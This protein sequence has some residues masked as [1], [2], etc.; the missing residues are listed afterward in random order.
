MSATVNAK[1]FINYFPIP[2]FKFA[3]IDAGEIPFYPIQEYFLE[4][5]GITIFSHFQK[6]VCLPKAKVKN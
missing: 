6:M 3:M 2:E 4:K 5:L 1:M